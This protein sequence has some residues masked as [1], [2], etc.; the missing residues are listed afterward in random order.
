MVVLSV[1]ISNTISGDNFECLYT[2]NVN[3]DGD[4]VLS[5][6][7]YITL[8]LKYIKWSLVNVE[9]MVSNK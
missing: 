6:F 2:F 1:H 9:F 5:A 3:D 4:F 7:E 8:M